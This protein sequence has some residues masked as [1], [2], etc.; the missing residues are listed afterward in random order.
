MGHRIDA[1]RVPGQ[2]HSVRISIAT[3]T[4]MCAPTTTF[5]LTCFTKRIVP[6]AV[7]S[8]WSLIQMD[9]YSNGNEDVHHV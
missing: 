2:L 1:T 9:S 6:V 8:L 7:N 3:T 5:P 4:R